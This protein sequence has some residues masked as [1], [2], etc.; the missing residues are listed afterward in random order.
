MLALRSP[1]ARSSLTP[2]TVTVCAV[3]QLPEVNVSDAGLTV[4]LPV[5]SRLTAMVTFAVGWLFS[6]TVNVAVPAGLGHRQPRP[7]T[8]VIPAVSSSVT[9]TAT[10]AGFEGRSS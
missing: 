4:A 8:T 2:V 5:A 7:S 10:S 3:F 1:V 9:V 6:T